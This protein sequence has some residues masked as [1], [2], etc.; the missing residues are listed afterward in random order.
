M[1]ISQMVTQQKWKI[2][3]CKM[4]CLKC[5]HCVCTH[6]I[7][8][9][10]IKP[11]ISRTCL[12]CSGVPEG[13]HLGIA[14]VPGLEKER[15]KRG[16][17]TLPQMSCV[18]AR[19]LCGGRG[20]LQGHREWWLAGLGLTEAAVELVIVLIYHDLAFSLAN[21]VPPSSFLL[22][23]AGRW[24]SLFSWCAEMWG[25]SPSRRDP[26]TQQVF[27]LDLLDDVRPLS[28]ASQAD[29]GTARPWW[30]SAGIAL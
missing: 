24:E 13:D 27:H 10:W 8:M 18:F 4:V 20:D 9:Q 22:M 7:T 17:C 23:A 15:R 16:P 26:S 2:R 11:A 3:I 25:T 12:V 6:V 5:L 21:W 14:G 28:P 1:V 29:T 30:E 19:V